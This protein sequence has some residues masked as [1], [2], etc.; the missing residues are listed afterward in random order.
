[1]VIIKL[2]AHTHFKEQLGSPGLMFSRKPGVRHTD[3]SVSKPLEAQNLESEERPTH[4]TS[5]LKCDV[6]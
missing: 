2:E 6:Y 5:L 3:L 1:M 4:V